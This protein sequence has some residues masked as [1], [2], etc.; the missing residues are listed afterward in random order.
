V[1][2]V[3]DFYC[4][5][6]ISAALNVTVTDGFFVLPRNLT[7]ASPQSCEFDGGASLTT[8][9][10]AVSEIWDEVIMGEGIHVYN[11]GLFYMRG[12]GM[13]GTPEG[14]LVSNYFFNYG[15]LRMERDAQKRDPW[16]FAHL[17]NGPV[18][19]LLNNNADVLIF[20]NLTNSGTVSV[21]SAA[22]LSIG[23][24]TYEQ[25]GGLTDMNSPY[26]SVAAQTDEGIGN[27]TISGGM[28]M[29]NAQGEQQS[30]IL[31]NLYNTGGT[32][33]V[34]TSGI[35]CELD[36]RYTQGPQG[37]TRILYVTFTNLLSRMLTL[38]LAHTHADTYST[39]D[40]NR[41][42]WWEVTQE[43]QN[44]V[45]MR[46]ANWNSYSQKCRASILPSCTNSLLYPVH[47]ITPA[48]S[49]TPMYR[50]PNP[51]WVPFNSTLPTLM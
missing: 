11:Y 34:N 29:I 37:V 3:T 14:A 49:A 15:F 36:G 18:G 20:G 35:S 40:L 42:C 38:T 43:R 28:L 51:L 27:I 22:Y 6:T 50:C 7:L 8:G 4:G 45:A 48:L 41:G 39:R 2:I 1:L 44:Q 5:G 21:G 24:G 33:Y 26:F 12:R 9:P 32:F 13:Q 23:G 10:E 17:I 19:N 25:T 46:R 16:I 31:G 30:V 47:R